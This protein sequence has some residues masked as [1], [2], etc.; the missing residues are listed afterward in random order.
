TLCACMS[1]FIR[2]QDLEGVLGLP[3][4]KIRVIRPAP[5][6][7]GG[8][9]SE[10]RGQG[11]QISGGHSPFTTHGSSLTPRPYVFYPSSFRPHKNHQVLVETLHWM[12]THLR[13]DSLDLVFTGIT[14]M[15]EKLARLIRAYGLAHRIH[16][17]GCVDRSKLAALYQSALATIVPSLYE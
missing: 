5:P 1:A 11:S 10:V 2:D 8:Q 15:P 4:K 12:R 14:P 17:L 13:E 7:D 16:V 6:V 3:E 9:E